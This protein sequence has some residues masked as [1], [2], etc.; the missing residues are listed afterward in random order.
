MPTYGEWPP[1]DLQY[2]LRNIPSSELKAWIVV[3]GGEAPKTELDAVSTA[4]QLPQGDLRDLYLANRLRARRVAVTWL[5]NVK[6]PNA[7]AFNA[8]FALVDPR[9]DV[10]DDESMFRVWADSE[11]EVITLRV[12]YREAAR[13]VRRGLE[14][15]AVNQFGVGTFVWRQLNTSQGQVDLLEVHCN[16]RWTKR[17]TPTLL[18][19][20]GLPSDGLQVLD[21]R[22][23]ACP[24]AMCDSLDGT[25]TDCVAE[26]DDPKIAEGAMTFSAKVG[27]DLNEEDALFQEYVAYP[28]RG[29]SVE[30]VSGD[31]RVRFTVSQVDFST[32]FNGI[33][34]SDTAEVF[35]E[36]NAVG[37]WI[38]F[39]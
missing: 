39:P 12:A 10:V 16:S 30:Y 34:L 1:P 20:M 31:R 29:R 32:V 2:V 21:I 8:S 38:A 36:A 18:T 6:V 11:V 23:N 15:V 7:D 27:R 19:R 33:D 35:E 25:F 22:D 28:G 37:S 14:L 13:L 4:M 9:G 3:H 26:I 5:R 24:K 17:L